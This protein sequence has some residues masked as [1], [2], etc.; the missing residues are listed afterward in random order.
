MGDNRKELLKDVA[1]VCELTLYS[2]EMNTKLLRNAIRE[3][4]T[5]QLLAPV[6]I[7]TYPQFIPTVKHSLPENSNVSLST[8]VAWPKGDGCPEAIDA[9]IFNAIGYYKVHEVE[10]VVDYRSFIYPMLYKY[11]HQLLIEQMDKVIG[12]ISRV[13]SLIGENTLLK[14]VL[15]I[16]EIH[17]ASRLSSLVRCAILGG[18]DFI[19][20]CT[21]KVKTNL[22]SEDLKYLL[23]EISFSMKG[24]SPCDKEVAAGD[25]E[26]L[27]ECLQSYYDESFVNGTLVL[28]NRLRYLQKRTVGLKLQGGVSSIEIAHDFIKQVEQT[29][30]KEYISSPNTFRIG[31][32]TLHPIIINELLGLDEELRI[33]HTL[34]MKQ[35]NNEEQ[36]DDEIVSEK[37]ITGISHPSAPVSSNN[38]RE[39]ATLPE[40]EFKKDIIKVEALNGINGTINS[41]VGH[42]DNKSKIISVEYVIN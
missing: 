1:K 28:P 9:E 42:D 23:S 33:I 41:D 31:S 10:Y 24:E 40:S 12:E 13:K 20:T 16:G 26:E 27:L 19:V 35:P 18:A 7:S 38:T 34:G 30:G 39:N 4:M 25:D 5:D 29:L 36:D 15:E 8:V 21:G 22:N 37:E 32:S 3:A 2:S 17:E 6:S 11:T 14:V